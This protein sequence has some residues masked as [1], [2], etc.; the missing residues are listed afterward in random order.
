AAL[1]VIERL[2]AGRMRTWAWAIAGIFLL[3]SHAGWV[4]HWDVLTIGTR[5]NIYRD[6]S[7]WVQEHTPANAVIVS[8]QVSGALYYY[9]NHPFLRWDML[10]DSWPRV[11]TALAKSGRPVYGVFFDFEEKPAMTENTPGHWVKLGQIRQ[12]SLWR[13]DL[14]TGP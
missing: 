1:L 13:L 7:R 12:A 5:E 4:C 2:A 8:M 6:T 3:A 11:Q 10:E 9:T 14:V